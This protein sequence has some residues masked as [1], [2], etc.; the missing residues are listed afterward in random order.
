MLDA[1]DIFACRCFFFTPLSF[2]APLLM[3]MRQAYALVYSN[4]H[5]RDANTS[6]AMNTNTRTRSALPTMLLAFRQLCHA[7]LLYHICRCHFMPL[8]AAIRRCFRR[9]SRH[10]T[11][12]PHARS[13][14]IV[15][16]EMLTMSRRYRPVTSHNIL[17]SQCHVGYAKYTNNN[18][19][20]I[21]YVM[22]HRQHRQHVRDVRPR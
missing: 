7:M 6:M 8:Y 18:R 13:P 21:H 3:R 4:T 17:S 5:A 20:R 15:A 2:R 16:R 1:T 12:M 11:L 22:R 10:F 9:Y 19:I 14:L